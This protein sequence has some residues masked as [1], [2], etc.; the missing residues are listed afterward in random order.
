MVVGCCL[1]TEDDVDQEMVLVDAACYYQM[2]REDEIA[3]VVE[4]LALL[5]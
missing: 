4:N 1:E 3:L 2:G 5:L